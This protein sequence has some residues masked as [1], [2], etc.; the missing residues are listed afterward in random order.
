MGV[1]MTGVLCFVLGTALITVYQV[2][3]ERIRTEI[4]G[5]IQRVAG[6]ADWDT[7]Q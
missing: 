1:L 6:E 2:A 4:Y 7:N 5:L 3:P